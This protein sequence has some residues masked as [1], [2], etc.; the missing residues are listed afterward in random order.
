MSINAQNMD[1]SSRIKMQYSDSLTKLKV[2]EEKEKQHKSVD[3]SFKNAKSEINSSAN[4]K[5][6]TI[7]GKIDSSSRSNYKKDIKNQGKSSIQEPITKIKET[8]TGL[9]NQAKSMVKKSFQGKKLI[10]LSGEIRSENFATTAQNPLMR[11]ELMYSRLYV[12]PTVTLLG[13]PFRANFFFTTEANNVYK[14]NFFTFRFDANAFRQ[15]A[16]SDLQKQID[17]AKKTDRLRQLDIQKNNIETQRYENELNGLKNRNPNIDQFKKEIQEQAEKKAQ[18][19]IEKE[20]IKLE[21]K[22]K[23]AGE[24]EKKKLERE[25]Q[26]KKD[27][28][29]LRHKNDVGDSLLSS[30]GN[31]TSKSDSMQMAKYLKLQQKLDELNQ[32]KK[33]I[34]ALRQHDSL[35]IAQ[36]ANGVKNPD[37]LRA[38]AKEQM[39]GNKLMQHALSIDRFG[40]GVVNPQYSEHTLFAASVKG[41]DIGVN[42]KGYFYDLTLGKT[43]KQFTGMFSN[44]LPAFDRNIVVSRFG[45]GE[46]K[47]DYLAVELLHAYDTKQENNPNEIN[48]NNVQIKNTVVNIGGRYTF[49]KSTEIQTDVAQSIYRDFS[50][51]KVIKAQGSSKEIFRPTD[52]RS[53][54]IKAIHTLSENTKFEMVLRQTGLGF[55]SVGNPFLRRNFREVEGKF[56]H[57]MFKKKVKLSASYKELRDNL[58][59]ISQ[60]INR[61]KGYGIK[62]S[63]T[64]EKHPNLTLSYSPYQQDN[65]HPDSLYKTNNQFSITNAILTYKRRYKSLNW[66]GLASYVRSGIEINQTGLVAYKMLNTTHTVQIGSKNISVV[67]WMRNITAPFVDS[68]NSESIQFNHTYL[69]NVKSSI[70]VIGERTKFK[71]G[72]YKIGGGLQFNVHLM[73]N[74]TLSLLS[75]YDR[76]HK[77]WHLDNA[78]VFTGRV[79]AVWRW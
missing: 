35:K 15:K 68:L 45:L 54:N 79:M 24:E 66:M 42:R 70:G 57:K 76:I 4:N 11:N 64:F 20:K 18:E 62:V 55:K 46:F 38:L 23:N 78:N 40:I 72:A 3:S 16:A 63:T 36:K 13:L 7:E 56:E 51:T 58:V 9:K 22:L 5:I 17:E 10:I 26:L 73:R 43:T 27:S 44:N 53:Y 65:N 33:D 49:L 41:I 77:L 34:E 74:F 67:S 1:N 31:W 48:N 69:A 8:P 47:K 6:N 28:I 39:K 29:L 32:K 12:S 61:L 50:S 60:A 2:S 14:N 25:F 71:N 30:S 75:R 37:D 59:E 52:F 21:N 19:Q